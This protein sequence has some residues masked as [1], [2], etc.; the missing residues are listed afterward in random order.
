MKKKIQISNGK[1]N[2]QMRRL[3][4]VIF[5]AQTIGRWYYLL[6]QNIRNKTLQWSKKWKNVKKREKKGLV[7]KENLLL[8]KDKKYWKAKKN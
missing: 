1:S 6:F 5:I 3:L 7:L 2:M 8:R 4:K